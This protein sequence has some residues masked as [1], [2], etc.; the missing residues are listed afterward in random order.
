MEMVPVEKVWDFFKEKEEELADIY[1]LLAE[2]VEEDTEVY[3]TNEGGSPV[4]TV[5][6]GGH[7]IQEIS[8]DSPIET[9]DVYSD[10][11]KEYIFKLP[12]NSETEMESETAF[13]QGDLDRLE[14]LATI[15]D[16]IMFAL[17][18][19]NGT[20]LGLGKEDLF[21]L[22]DTI[23]CFLWENYEIPV[24]HP[25]LVEDEETGLEMVMPYPYDR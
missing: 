8:T 6:M 22:L 13:T 5:E 25:Y 23:E 18:G 11:L 15:A 19:V 16:E 14:E 1:M 24:W 21:D 2:N 7:L 4:I 3:I 20:D 10:V 12:E 17:L 9:E